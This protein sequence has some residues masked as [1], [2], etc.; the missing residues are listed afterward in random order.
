MHL[1]RF[2]SCHE[3]L[4]SG[5]HPTRDLA[6]R[7]LLLGVF[8]LTGINPRVKLVRDSGVMRASSF[9]TIVGPS[10]T[11][12]IIASKFADLSPMMF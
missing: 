5:Y 4:H 8:I 1:L 6:I 2:V 11:V 9:A 12:M 7:I 3:F 10:W